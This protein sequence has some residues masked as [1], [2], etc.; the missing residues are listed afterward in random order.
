MHV[1]QYVQPNV[2]NNVPT[3]Y[4]SLHNVKEAIKAVGYVVSQAQLFL[5][6]SLYVKY[7]AQL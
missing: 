4:N 7:A 6:L 3:L 2:A 1:Q 5:Y